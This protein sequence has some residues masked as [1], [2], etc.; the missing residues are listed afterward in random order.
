V[1]VAIAVGGTAAGAGVDVQTGTGVLSG[2]THV[3]ALAADEK[4]YRVIAAWKVIR[5][6]YIAPNLPDSLPDRT[7][8]HRIGAMSG[9]SSRSC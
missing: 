3:C 8:H 6:K 7:R 1:L 2:S 9:A 4:A 5:S